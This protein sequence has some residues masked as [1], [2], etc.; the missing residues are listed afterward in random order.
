M[1]IHTILELSGVGITLI[2][3]IYSTG[4][5]VKETRINSAIQ[6]EMAKDI[7]EIIAE[8]RNET[9]SIKMDILETRKSVEQID[10]DLKSIRATQ[11]AFSRVAD[12]LEE[13]LKQK[14]VVLAKQEEKISQLEK[15]VS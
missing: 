10:H 8:I 12:T 11:K 2:T 13:E 14:S 6:R 7:S 3:L 15:K 1:P 9:V 5:F 4:M